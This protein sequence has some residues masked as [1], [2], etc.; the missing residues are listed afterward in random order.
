MY[1]ITQAS[2]VDAEN[3]LALQKTAY[4]SEAWIYNDWTLPPLTQSLASLTAEFTDYIILKAVDADRIIGSVRAK[5]DGTLCMIE[6]LIVHP[7]YQRQGLGTSLLHHIEMCFPLATRLELF[8]GSKSSGNIR[9]YEK[10]GYV[11]TRTQ[12]LSPAVS[13]IYLEKQLLKAPTA[14]G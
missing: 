8:T 3:I 14:Q 12:S 4:Q 1:N 9:L 13:L 2:V 10:N 7:D 5:S 11:I 6:K